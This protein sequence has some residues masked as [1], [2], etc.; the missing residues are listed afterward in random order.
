MTEEITNEIEEKKGFK[1][2]KCDE[3]D[4]W[5]R[6]VVIIGGSFVGCLLALCVYNTFAKPPIPPC[7]RPMP[8]FEH[9]M[10]RGDYGAYKGEYRHHKKYR[11]EHV[12]K[13]FDKAPQRPSTDKPSSPKK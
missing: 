13:D 5:R 8:A 12:R 6:F 1:I 10:P 3:C 11:G 2:C 4:V 7:P 9:R